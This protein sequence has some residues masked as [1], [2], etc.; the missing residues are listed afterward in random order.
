VR[1]FNDDSAND[2]RRALPDVI[3]SFLASGAAGHDP[4]QIGI[5][6]TDIHAHQVSLVAF[7]M[8]AVLAV[9]LLQ[10]GLVNAG[11]ASVREWQTGSVKELLLSP[12]PPLGV[13]AGKVAAGVIAADSVGCLAV[14]VAVAAGIMPL[15]GTADLALALGA[16]TLLGLFASALG[17]AVAA[18]VRIQ[19]RM[20][21]ISINLSFYLFFLGGGI[22]ALAYLPGWLRGV[23]R[24]NP[25]TYAVDVLR[26][27]LLYG[28]TPHAGTDFLVLGL[29]A[30]AALALGVPVLRRGLA[31]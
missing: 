23:A 20:V 8:I 31:H 7:Q 26:G 3:S 2:L 27:A 18:R 12:V 14:A 6:E 16:M 29:S 1:N 28:A 10:A 13:V 30:A 25:V 24:F 11:L 5:Q 9:L 15:P 19:D 22:V 4:V 17:V 21:P